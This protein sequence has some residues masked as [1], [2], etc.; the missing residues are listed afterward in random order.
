MISQKG[1]KKYIKCKRNLKFLTLEIYKHK[2]EQ[3]KELTK[4]ANIS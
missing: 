1:K 2:K 3:F 4:A